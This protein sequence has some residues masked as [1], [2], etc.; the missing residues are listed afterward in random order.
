MPARSAARPVAVLAAAVLTTA[1]V[2][3]AGCGTSR[4]PAAP[5]VMPRNVVS[6]TPS[7]VFAPAEVTIAAGDSVTWAFAGVTHTV[8][9]QRPGGAVPP[10]VPVVAAP[11]APADVGPTSEASVTR[12]FTTRGTFGYGCRLHPG[13]GGLV[14]V[15]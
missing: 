6:A 9:F 14:R 8:V 4:N 3:A 1:G 7:L 13:M 12:V 10:G 11:G 15:Q 5:A 2:A